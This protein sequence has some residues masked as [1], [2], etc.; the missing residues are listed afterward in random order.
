MPASHLRAVVLPGDV[1]RDVFVVDGRITFTPVDEAQ[2]V[3]SGGW[4]LPGLV[5]PMPTWRWSAHKLSE[6]VTG[7]RLLDGRSR[8]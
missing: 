4:L 8:G 5:D 3:F 2:T 7:A 6:V 1:A